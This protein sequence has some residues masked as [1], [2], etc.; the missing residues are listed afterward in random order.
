MQIKISPLIRPKKEPKILSN[1]VVP[2]E[3]DGLNK[4]L[5]IRSIRVDVVINIS[6]YPS[7]RLTI[8]RNIFRIKTREIN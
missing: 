4:M 5:L 3:E 7:I 1:S 2:K 8:R 6:R